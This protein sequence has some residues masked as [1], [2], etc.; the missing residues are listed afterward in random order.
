MIALLMT[1]CLTGEPCTQETLA[2]FPQEDVGLA[3]CDIAKPAIESAIRSRARSG[4]VVKFSCSQ[5]EMPQM[6]GYSPRQRDN[7]VT[8]ADPG[9]MS[10]IDAARAIIEK[11]AK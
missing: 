2:F 8:M 3:L 4:A 11:I 5:S 6:P 10:A 7:R 1:Y 9:K